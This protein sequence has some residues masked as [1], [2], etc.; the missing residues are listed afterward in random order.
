MVN[1][2][3]PH[4]FFVDDEPKMFEVIGE[5]LVELGPKISCF[6]NAADC[7]KQLD[8]QRCDLVIT[9]VKMPG[10]DGIELLTEI[11]RSAP[12]LPVMVITGYGDIQMA[13]S[14]AAECY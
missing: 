1:N 10:M 14:P 12:W 7:L 9:D 6:T 11:R 5:I 3:K 13:V 8:S 4:I 2:T